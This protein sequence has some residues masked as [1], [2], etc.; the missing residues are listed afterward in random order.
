MFSAASSPRDAV[1]LFSRRIEER[2]KSGGPIIDL[3]ESNPTR[4]GFVYDTP[5]ILQAVASTASMSYEPHPQGLRTARD[6]IVDSYRERG[7]EADAEA[8]F[9]TSGTSEAYAHLFK[10]LAIRA[11]RSLCPSP[12]IRCWKCSHGWTVCVW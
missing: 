3:T 4:C 11:M 10:L 1:N 7:T 6:A 5:A 12:V 9:L 2:R 8:L